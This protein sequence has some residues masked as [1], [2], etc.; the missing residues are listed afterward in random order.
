MTTDN[1]NADSI[2]V[3]KG[4]DPVK[5]R[6][7]MY[8]RTIN[9]NHIIEEVID[10]A[11]D[12]ALAGFASKIKVRQLKT[13]EIVVEDNGRGIPIDMHPDEGIPAVEVIFTILHSGGKFNKGEE[14]NPYAFSGGL[15]GVGVSV[16]NA[17]SEKLTVV[18]KKNGGVHQIEFSNGFVSKPLEKIGETNRSGTKIIVEPNPKYFDDI[19][20]DIKEIK[21]ILESKAMLLQGIEFELVIEKETE[22]NEEFIWFYE[23]GLADF[24]ENK[25]SEDTIIY[26]DERYLKEDENDNYS[27]GEGAAWAIS[28]DEHVLIRKSFVNLINTPDGGTH[29]NGIKNALFEGVKNYAEQHALLPKGVKLVADD[30]FSKASLVLS[31]KIL[32][33]E[34]QGQ[35]KDRLNNR[36]AYNLMSLIV[37]DQ[38]ETWLNNNMNEAERIA[39]LSIENAKN[40]SKKSKKEIDI[41]SGGITNLPGKLTDCETK[42]PE[43]GELFI[44]EG[45][46]AGGSAKQ[47]RDRIFQAILPAKGKVNNTWEMPHENLLDHEE[48]RNISIAIGVKPHKIGDENVDL[49]QLRYHKICI[50]ADADV[51][52]YH[53][54]VLLLTLFAKHYHKLIEHG[55]IYIAQP[56][57]FKVEVKGK[58]KIKA[59]GSGGKFYAL[60][61]AELDGIKKKCAKAKL[62]PEDYVVGRFKG[63]GE[64]NPDQLR[65]TTLSPDTRRLKRVVWDEDFIRTFESLDM[66]MSKKRAD[67]RKNWIE[68]EGVFIE[69]EL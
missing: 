25:F 69:E 58:S 61:E 51:D 57:L 68:D 13:G 56:P 31:S 5:E 16:T 67:D 26:S 43:E 47:G 42:N 14:G 64:M 3:L 9:P 22:E 45:D 28:W 33:P 19:T 24:L 18:V 55:H 44:V 15:H 59:V 21:E 1:Y 20:V 49:S 60:D 41:R 65:E 32:D 63:L 17:L 54:Q 34:F 4:L 36:A 29:V 30:V 38:F 2:G 11:C 27:T 12:E 37:K 39:K 7:G 46:S 35:T 62:N 10:N 50:L 8:T 40:R 23:N 66:I 53:I 48:I 6:P 52:G